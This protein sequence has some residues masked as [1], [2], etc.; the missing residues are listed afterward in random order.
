[1]AAFT[2]SADAGFSDSDAPPAFGAFDD[3]PQPT[4][5]TAVT[6]ASAASARR[7]TDSSVT[8]SR[9]FICALSLALRARP[10]AEFVAPLPRSID[11]DLEVVV[12]VVVHAPRLVAVD[13]RDG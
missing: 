6:A 12:G 7:M 4:S 3:D 8:L 13:D 11:L 2:S 9:L 10:D 5:V 1:M